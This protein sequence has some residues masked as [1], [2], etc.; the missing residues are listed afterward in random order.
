[1]S[2]LYYIHFLSFLVLN[3]LEKKYPDVDS[4]ANREKLY[5]KNLI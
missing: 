5:E 1:M 3:E 4:N 2:K